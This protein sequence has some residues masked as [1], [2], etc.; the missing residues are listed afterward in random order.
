MTSAHRPPPKQNGPVFLPGRL[1]F[2]T[3][4][5]LV[6]DLEQAGCALAAAD[7]HRHDAILRLA[8]FAF[9]QDMAVR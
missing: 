7:A 4:S 5:R 9:E 8:A 6:E 1:H 2:R 3:T